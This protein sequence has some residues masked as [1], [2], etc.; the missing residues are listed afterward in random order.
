MKKNRVLV[1]MIVVMIV[2]SNVT[3]AG[4]EEDFPRLMSHPIVIEVF[5]CINNWINS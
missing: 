1:I 4:Q 5:E 3:F 2:M